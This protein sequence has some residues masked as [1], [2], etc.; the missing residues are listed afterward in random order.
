MKSGETS[1]PLY[2][3]TSP[4]THA[5]CIYEKYNNIAKLETYAIYVR[6][7]LKNQFLI[8]TNVRSTTYN[9]KSNLQV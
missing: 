1:V 9:A 3:R 7:K 4:L 2:S 6:T 8:E 5:T